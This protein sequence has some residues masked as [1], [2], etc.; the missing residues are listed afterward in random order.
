MYGKGKA[1]VGAH[2]LLKRQI[3]DEPGQYVALNL[4]AQGVE[5]TLKSL[6][7]FQDYDKYRPRLQKRLGHNLVKTASATL[8][9]L[10]LKPLRE[11]L[12]SE[13]ARLSDFYAKHLLRYGNPVDILV[14]PSSIPSDPLLR[15][16]AAATRLAEREHRRTG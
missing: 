6:L 7:L 15:R 5:V 9:A 2:L 4:L 11:P 8:K 12:D 10:S 14:A 1:F 16:I 3:A 13:L